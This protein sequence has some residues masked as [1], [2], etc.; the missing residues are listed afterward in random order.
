MMELINLN[1]CESII[2]EVNAAGPIAFH[3]FTKKS[4]TEKDDDNDNNNK[5]NFTMP[6]LF[7]LLVLHN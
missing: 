6:S 7:Y 5:L 4:G 2:W 3:S 1:C